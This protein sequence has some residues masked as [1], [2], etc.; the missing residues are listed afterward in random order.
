MKKCWDYIET[1]KSEEKQGGY[2]YGYRA[3]LKTK[4]KT[5]PY[6]LA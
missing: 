1:Y 2:M 3:I 4:K 6:E 5:I